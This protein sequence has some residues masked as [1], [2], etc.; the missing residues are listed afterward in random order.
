MGRFRAI[1][2]ALALVV[3]GSGVGCAVNRTI[4]GVD[5][6]VYKPVADRN[7]I[8]PPPTPAACDPLAPGDAVDPAGKV[9]RSALEGIPIGSTAV[10]RGAKPEDSGKRT[11]RRVDEET[12]EF[13][14]DKVE[15]ARDAIDHGSD[16]VAAQMI[17]AALELRPREPWGE[18]LRTM[19]IEIRARRLE[20]DVIRVDVR[21]VREYVVFESDV[22]LLVRLRNVGSADLVILPPSGAGKDA[23]SG[24][25][26]VISL[27]RRDRDVYAAELVRSWT[28][29]VPLVEEGGC[30]VRIPP[31]GTYEVR[32]RVPADDAGP[33]LAGLRV[34]EVGGDLL[35]G[36]IEAG[37][38]EPLGRIRIRPGR[39]VVLPKNYE[40]LAADPIGSMKKAAT[41]VAPVHLLVATE[42][43]A[44]ADRP[45]AVAVLADALSTGSL[46][47][48]MT[49]QN[50]LHHLRTAATGALVRPLAEPLM[51]A[52]RA[53]PERERELMEALRALTG[54]SLAPDVRLW[55]DWWRR[56]SVGPTA[57]V[58]TD[59][60]LSAPGDKARG[61]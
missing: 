10:G 48:A 19:R 5:R 54:V 21:G 46:D 52:L 15:A 31:D 14:A 8:A 3:S 1:P 56:G 34:L 13:F 39:V 47:L 53:H 61:R 4:G 18:R 6:A 33:P 49:A 60:D 27:K 32:V 7:E 23:L 26:L 24:S 44:P 43:V 36:R 29:S 51:A 58:P 22:D 2:V 20:A 41:A 50:A 17:D 25:T 38:S 45:A 57:V 12:D 30:E 28:R 9:D 40:P 59:E 37:L 55:D 42:F 16:E 11:R 35:A